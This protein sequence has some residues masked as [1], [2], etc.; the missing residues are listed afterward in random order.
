[1]EEDN[2]LGGAAGEADLCAA[3]KTAVATIRGARVCYVHKE[4]TRRNTG[5]PVIYLV[6]YLGWL[7]NIY[8]GW[9]CE[10]QN[11]NKLGAL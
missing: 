1:M 10:G 2:N 8:L 5:G 9:L 11:N 4:A 3:F 6:I 7:R